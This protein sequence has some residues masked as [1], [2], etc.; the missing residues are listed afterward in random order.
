M[1]RWPS[2]CLGGRLDLFLADCPLRGL[3]QFADNVEGAADDVA[4]PALRSVLGGILYLDLDVPGSDTQDRSLAVIRDNRR[5]LVV[6]SLASIT[7][8]IVG[9]LLLGVVRSLLLVPALVLLLLLSGVKV[10][11]HA[12]N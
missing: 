2:D 7:G 12:P 3:G 6:I 9:G 11:R 4:D 8:T 10:W 5:F 1:C